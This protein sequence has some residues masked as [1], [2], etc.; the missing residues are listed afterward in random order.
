MLHSKNTMDRFA[1][2]ILP[3]PEA[4]C[5][6]DESLSPTIVSF[7]NKQEWVS[8]KKCEKQSD[9]DVRE[10][11]ANAEVINVSNPTESAK[12]EWE[13]YDYKAIDVTASHK[14]WQ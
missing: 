7:A 3:L 6:A 11:Q 5:F 9:D 14:I 4:R 13:P 10:Q 12:C 1:G 2:V 8:R